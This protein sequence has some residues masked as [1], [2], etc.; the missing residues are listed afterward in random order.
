MVPK[1]LY[2]NYHCLPKVIKIPL[3][4]YNNLLCLL[5]LIFRNSNEILDGQRESVNSYIN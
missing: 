3:R 4:Y 1:T 5:Y 2:N